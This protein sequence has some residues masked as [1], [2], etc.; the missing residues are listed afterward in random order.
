MN[1]EL[2]R[3][4]NIKQAKQYVKLKKKMEK[5]PHQ[6]DVNEKSF[7]ELIDKGLEENK[8]NELNE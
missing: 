5:Y 2:I 1:Q 7:V 4:K 8:E 6:L 3:Q